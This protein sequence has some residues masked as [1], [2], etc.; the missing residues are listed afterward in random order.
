MDSF[1]TK[2]K[3]RK[4]NNFGSI[5]YLACSKSYLKYNTHG[6]FYHY[7]DSIWCINIRSTITE[8]GSVVQMFDVIDMLSSCLR[9][10]F[11]D[12]W[13][14]ARHMALAGGISTFFFCSVVI[15]LSTFPNRADIQREREHLEYSDGSQQTFE[16]DKQSEM[17]LAVAAVLCACGCDCC[18]DFRMGITI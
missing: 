6:W 10:G 9:F 17:A 8:H 4:Q 11:R 16:N 15:R 13:S 5:D 2:I 18:N 12:T 7:P 3:S 14:P 1:K